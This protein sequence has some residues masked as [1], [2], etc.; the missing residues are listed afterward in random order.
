AE[1]VNF[2]RSIIEFAKSKGVKVFLY[3]PPAYHTY[4]DNLDAKQ[5]N[6]TIVT[7]I[8]M[9]NEYSNV[10]YHNFLLDPDFS[11]E[12]FYDGDHLNKSGA[13]KL[14]IKIDSIININKDALSG[15]KHNMQ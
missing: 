13:K 14:T 4:T 7:L 12:D 15:S 8:N 5:L 10:K 9:A 3:T 6:Q 2:L 1:N 11:S